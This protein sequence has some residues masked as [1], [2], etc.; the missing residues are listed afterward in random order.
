MLTT[1][2]PQ[3]NYDLVR[4]SDSNRIWLVTLPNCSIKRFDES[5]VYGNLLNQIILQISDQ[6]IIVFVDTEVISMTKV[7]AVL[8]GE[9]L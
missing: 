6:E 9:N 5:T 3:G 2:R 8:T 7:N 4:F 1:S